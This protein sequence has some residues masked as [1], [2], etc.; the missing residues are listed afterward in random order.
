MRVAS[1]PPPT[2]SAPPIPY[3]ANPAYPPN[4]AYGGYP[5][6]PP[7]AGY[8]TYP[9]YPAYPSYP[10]YQS[11]PAYPMY[12]GPYG[13]PV[14]YPYVQPKPGKD[15]F[16][17]LRFLKWAVGL[18]ITFNLLVLLSNMLL[19]AACGQL[20]NAITSHS[21]AAIGA[22]QGTILAAT[23]AKVIGG[24]LAIIGA[25]VGY[26][27]IGFTSRGK[28][29]FGTSHTRAVSRGVVLTIVASIVYG[30]YFVVTLVTNVSAEGAINSADITSLLTAFHTMEGGLALA[31]LMSLGAAVLSCIA[32]TSLVQAL[33]TRSGQRRRAVFAGLSVA[34][35]IGVLGMA[36]VVPGM[37]D[38]IPVNSLST[39]DLLGTLNG[40]VGVLKWM[41][42][43]PAIENFIAIIALGLF[44]G[45]IST[46]QRGAQ[47]MIGSGVF[48]PDAPP[49]PAAPPSVP[50]L[51]AAVYAP[52]PPG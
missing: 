10:A 20:Q 19:Y 18:M 45:M 4:P 44:V 11:Y 17:G 46:A 34:G 43:V 2:P 32:L 30:L 38:A 12:P 50:A 47:N 35:P 8:P 6:Y 36:L 5:A 49:T 16:G 29:E 25:V 26:V 28:P 7:A 39:S 1:P 21:L 14:G 31:S 24:I 9:N 51:T 23:A 15:T 3:I 13:V 52:R 37:V 40:F 41:A 27:A 33:M 22:A 42:L 48:D